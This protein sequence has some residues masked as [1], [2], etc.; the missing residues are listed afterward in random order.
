MTLG[1]DVE[2]KYLI[3]KKWLKSGFSLC[4]MTVAEALSLVCTSPISEILTKQTNY[5]KIVGFV[6]FLPLNS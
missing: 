5:L 4:K 2:L 3:V 1:R 6:S